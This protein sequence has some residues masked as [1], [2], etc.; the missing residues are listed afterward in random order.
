MAHNTIIISSEFLSADDSLEKSSDEKSG[1]GRRQIPTLP[2]IPYIKSSTF[3]AKHKSDN[4]QTP[5]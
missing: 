3:P 4:E 5:L 1:S 2:V